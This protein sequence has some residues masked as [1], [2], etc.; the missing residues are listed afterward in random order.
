MRFWG[1]DMEI[2]CRCVGCSAK[3]KVDAKYAGKKARCPKCQAVVDVPLAG[4][5][6]TVTASVSPSASA[7]QIA[8]PKSSILKPVATRLGTTTVAIP[9]VRQVPA[10]PV[11]QPQLPPEPEPEPVAP[12][13]SDFPSFTTKLAPAG[14]ALPASSSSQPRGRKKS[15][16]LLLILG[17]GALVVVAGMVA[18]GVFVAT[19]GDDKSGKGGKPAVASSANKATLVLDWPQAQ[20]SGGAV[21]IDGKPYK[22][23]GAGTIKF[24]LP[25]GEHQVLFLRRGYEPFDS[26]VTL[27]KGELEHLSPRWTAVAAASPTPG[28]NEIPG[29]FPIPS[30]TSVPGFDGWHQMLEAAKG[31]AAREKKDLL[32]VLGC[33]DAQP[34]TQEL[35][36]Q[37]EQA[38]VRQSYACLVLDFPAS[39]DGL[40]TVSDLAQNQMLAQQFGV[41]VRLPSLVL[42]DDQGRA[43]FMKRQ[44][45]D[46]FD[47]MQS[48]VAQWSKNKGERDAL[49]AAASQGDQPGQLAAAAKAVKWLQDQNVW[50]SH[51]PEIQRWLVAAQKAD[52]ENQQ[53]LLEVFFEPQWLMDLVEINH[54]EASAVAQVT[55]KLDPW[56]ARKFHDPDRGAKLHLT[57]S[58]LLEQI[59]RLDEATAQIEHAIKYQPKDA[60]LAE[61]IDMFKQELANRDLL[62][63]GSGF[64]VSSDGY[65]LTNHHVIEG[66]GRIEVRLSGET[67]TLAAQ[68]VATNAVR[69]MALLKVALPPG[70]QFRSLPV[71]VG[72]LKDGSSIASFGHPLGDALGTGV[73]SAQGSVSELPE[74]TRNKM[75]ALDLRVNRGNSGG[76]LCDLQGNVVGMI[77]SKFVGAVGDDSIGFAIPAADLFKF[78]NEHLPPDTPLAK[79]PAAEEKMDWPEVVDRVKPGVV[80][81]LNKKK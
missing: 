22:I 69:D 28:P 45:D 10:A 1:G 55:A 5:E 33:S 75:Y 21:K 48:K 34:A 63:T 80:M 66:E 51:G 50:R 3:F 73:K 54:E 78:L 74:T 47:E 23:P 27:A 2:R 9:V 79:P 31:Q 8:T 35:A 13:I 72:K 62:G 25:A 18:V 7:S 42:A 58:V 76:P 6:S 65:I 71:A 15:S 32:I 68:V 38:G 30:A 61:A 29:N 49:L 70:G 46:G 81:V 11:P 41:G 26:S 44:W 24:T 57:A 64:F 14:G 77:T 53:G 56:V 40:N 39:A 37:L 4:E 36:R 17:G 59:Q 19:S 16:P 60:E 67:E 52:P 20:R 12:T 43:Y